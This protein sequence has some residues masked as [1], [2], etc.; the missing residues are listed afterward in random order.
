MRALESGVGQLAT[1]LAPAVFSIDGRTLEAVV[2]DLLS[3]HGWTIAVAESC[4]GGLLLGRLTEVPGSSAWVI[5]GVVAYAND[6]K[7]QQ[8]GRSGNAD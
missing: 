1:A 2:G 3:A 5:G 6:V 8:L 7:T 4:T